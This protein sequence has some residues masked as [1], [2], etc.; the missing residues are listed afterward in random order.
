[1]EKNLNSTRAEAANPHIIV[2]KMNIAMQLIEKGHKVFT[3]M[4]NPQKPRLT[5]W[6]FERD[7]TIEDD[8]L[9]RAPLVVV[10]KSTFAAD[11][12]SEEINILAIL[13]TGLFATIISTLLVIC[14][15]LLSFFIEDSHPFYW[16]YSKLIL[17]IGTIFPIEYF[18]KVLQPIINLLNEVVE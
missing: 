15:G 8:D 2:Y 10:E 5:A 13:L 14:I 18:P 3:T 9:G 16:L 12:T 17:V 1:M 7:D 11:L 4:P 6:I